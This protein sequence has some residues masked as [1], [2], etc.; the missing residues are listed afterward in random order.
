MKAPTQQVVEVLTQL[1]K[2][3]GTLTPEDVIEHAK[4]PTSVLHEYFTWDPEKALEKNLLAEARTLI[5]SVKI[6][7]TIEEHTIQ[8][9]K[10]LRD[11]RQGHNQGYN[12]VVSIRKD[13][14]RAKETLVLEVERAL[15]ALK[16]AERV[17]LALNL[18]SNLAVPIEHVEAILDTLKE[19]LKVAAE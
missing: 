13:V 11:V 9:P 8:A 12:D 3:H 15:N 14:D 4:D 18:G 1:K 5:R 2:E 10:Y 16:R 6:E 19:A 17:S 7:I